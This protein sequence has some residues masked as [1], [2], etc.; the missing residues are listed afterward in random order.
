MF[1]STS[2]LYFI[3]YGGRKPKKALVMASVTLHNLFK[4]ENAAI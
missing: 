2:V 4:L 3:T 1:F